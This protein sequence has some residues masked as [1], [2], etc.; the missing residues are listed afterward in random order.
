[1][2]YSFPKYASI[3]VSISEGWGPA[4]VIVLYSPLRGTTFYEV[5]KEKGHI[6]RSPALWY[7]THTS[8]RGQLRET[9]NNL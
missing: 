6:Q 8:D 1:M 9:L 5:N 2:I 4:F 7:L 3:T